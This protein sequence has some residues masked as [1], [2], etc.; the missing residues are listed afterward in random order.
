M[1]TFFRL[2]FALLLFVCFSF[3]GISQTSG[4][5]V[6]ELLSKVDKLQQENKDK[7]NAAFTAMEA[8][9]KAGAY[10]ESLSDLFGNGEITLP[11]GT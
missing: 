3:K 7:I 8:V 9:K 6:N 2:S 5:S 10:I 1:R 11:V 4:T